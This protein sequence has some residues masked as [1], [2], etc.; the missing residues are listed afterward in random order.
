MYL[1]Q[2]QLNNNYSGRDYSLCWIH[3]ASSCASRWCLQKPQSAVR[4]SRKV[5][6][7]SLVWALASQG[8]E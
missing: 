6:C 4:P 3:C 5:F 8:F 1:T 7:A 2:T